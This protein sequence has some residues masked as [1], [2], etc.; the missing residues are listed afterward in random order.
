MVISVLSTGNSLEI[1][2]LSTGNFFGNSYVICRK[3]LWKFLYHLLDY[4]FNVWQ[5][6]FETP[7]AFFCLLP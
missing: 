1:S 3:L 5:S 4:R 6:S 7:A 2:V